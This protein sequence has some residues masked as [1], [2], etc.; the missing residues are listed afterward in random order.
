MTV[1]AKPE[2]LLDALGAGVSIS[3]GSLFVTPENLSVVATRL[4]DRVDFE[5]LD[6]ITAVDYPYYF[7]VVYRFVS[8]KKNESI[9]LKT[10]TSKDSPSIPS[11]AP[12]WQGADFQEREV[13]DLFG[14]T[15]TGHPGLKR[16][17]LWEGF[18]G[19]PLRKDYRI[20]A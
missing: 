1:S 2:T 18:Q 4:K 20:D 3:D 15:F 16:I 17:M 13:Y 14:I 5:Y 8:L 9:T 11:L 6:M 10:R 12:L 7:E 19:H